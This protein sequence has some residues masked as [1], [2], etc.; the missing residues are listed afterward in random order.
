MSFSAHL[1][2]DVEGVGAK[3]LSQPVP[4]ADSLNGRGCFC[5]WATRNEL[6]EGVCTA[7]RYR[8]SKN[9]GEKVACI[10]ISFLRRK[11]CKTSLPSGFWTNL[12]HHIP[13]KKWMW[14][15]KGPAL[16]RMFWDCVNR[17]QSF[18]KEEKQSHH[19]YFMDRVVSWHS[20]GVTSASRMC[21]DNS[22]SD[23]DGSRILSRAACPLTLLW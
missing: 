4:N 15:T 9:K 19:P 12:I 13:H 23:F 3:P 11:Q 17:Q 18:S 20:H 16:L 5:G 6:P 14:W 22:P 21:T 2:K 1:C 7:G 10:K 8:A